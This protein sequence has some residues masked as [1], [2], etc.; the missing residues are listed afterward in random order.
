MMR[1][2]SSHLDFCPSDPPPPRSVKVEAN[3]GAIFL[4][5]KIPLDI[6]AKIWRYEI[7]YYERGKM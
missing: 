5:W 1:L 6:G 2:T 4:S 7:E 3:Q